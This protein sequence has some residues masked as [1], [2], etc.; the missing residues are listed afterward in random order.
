MMFAL[1]RARCHRA[2]NDIHGTALSGRPDGSKHKHTNMQV[3]G[4]LPHSLKHIYSCYFPPSQNES[5]VQYIIVSI[6]VARSS[7]FVYLQ[8]LTA[9]I[10]VRMFSHL[11][12]PD[13]PANSI[14]F[15]CVCECERELRGN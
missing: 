14:T 5:N 1:Q 9:F 6:I 3:L 11:C 8:Q 10:T 13:C 12:V 4:L 15:V 7:L 2:T